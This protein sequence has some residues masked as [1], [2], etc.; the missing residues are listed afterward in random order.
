MMLK[1]F[2]KFDGSHG[3]AE[4]LLLRNRGIEKAKKG[5]AKYPFM[6]WLGVVC[7]RSCC[8]SLFLGLEDLQCD[9]LFQL[10][11]FQLPQR[12]NVQSCSPQRFCT[13]EIL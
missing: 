10:W 6:W 13:V 9:L 1:R 2:S 5:A 4:Y 7:K 12:E 3:S 11:M 8:S